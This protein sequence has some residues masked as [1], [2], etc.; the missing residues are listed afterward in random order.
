MNKSYHLAH[1]FGLRVKGARPKRKPDP[2]PLAAPKP[3]VKPPAVSF[4]HLRPKPPAPLTPQE[5][6]QQR[7]D[8][9]HGTKHD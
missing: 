7:I 4:D 1:L 2:P 5:R 3:K 6:F 8:R 9:I